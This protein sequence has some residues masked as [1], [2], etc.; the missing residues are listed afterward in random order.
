MDLVV[1]DARLHPTGGTR[2]EPVDV[3]VEGD[4]IVAIRPRGGLAGPH[5]TELE[6]DGRY[7]EADHDSFFE[8]FADR[9]LTPDDLAPFPDY[10]VCIPPDRNAS[11]ENAN[12][13]CRS[14]SIT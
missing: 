3:G 5:T 10:L 9:R 14:P 4:R 1:R 8:H 11:P 2:T 12:P 13:P 7:V 6:A